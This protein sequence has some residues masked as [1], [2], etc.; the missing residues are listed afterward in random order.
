MKEITLQMVC[1]LDEVEL[2]QRAQMLSLTTLKIDEVEDDKAEANKSFKEELN[3]LRESAR[4][5]SRTVNTKTEVRPVECWVEFH[6]PSQGTKR[7]T[8]KDTG[9]FYRDEPM[10]A[11]ECQTHLFEPDVNM[12]ELAQR[13]EAAGATEGVSTLLDHMRQTSALTEGTAGL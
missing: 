4:K 1:E 13:V 2:A 3:G 5:L 8:R 9:E 11:A 12:E 7:V 6:S 10:T